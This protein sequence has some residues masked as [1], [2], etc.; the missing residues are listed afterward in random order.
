MA[1]EGLTTG[2]HRPVVAR[3]VAVEPSAAGG[4]EPSATAGRPT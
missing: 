2:A 4:G 3:P 1:L